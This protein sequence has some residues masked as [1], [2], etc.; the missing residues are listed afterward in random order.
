MDRASFTT[1]GRNLNLWTWLRLPG[2]RL[3]K[4]DFH[5]ILLPSLIWI[6]AGAARPYVLGAPCFDNSN[7]CDVSELLAIDRPVPE[8][9]SETAEDISLITQYVTGAFL[10]FVPIGIHGARTYLGMISPAVA[11]SL[12]VTDITII[13]Q[14]VLWNGALMETARVGFQ[15]P[16]PFVYGDHIAAENPSHYTSFYSGHTSFVASASMAIFLILFSRFKVSG[17]QGTLLAGFLFSHTVVTGLMRV[18]NARHFV[19]DVLFAMFMGFLVALVIGRIHKR[20][21]PR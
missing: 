9:R 15:R 14:T 2:V 12:A 8:W 17:M 6:M 13:A 19:T 7:L 3:G 21:E 10:V 1:Q 20:K 5:L 16:R 18:L 11:L 4:L